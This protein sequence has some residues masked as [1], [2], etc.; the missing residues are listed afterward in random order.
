MPVTNNTV[1][2]AIKSQS[3]Y[4]TPSLQ[5]L[6]HLLW[7]RRGASGHVDQVWPRIYLGDKWTAK[8]KRSLQSLKITHILNAAD[9]KYNVCTGA[10][11]YSDMNIL[12]HGVEAFDTTAFDI[13][14][15]FYSAAKFIR[16]ALDTPGDGK[17]L[18]HCAM[19]L[20]RSAT[21][22]LAFLM[23]YENKTLVDAVKAVSEHRNIS[24]NMGFLGQLRELDMRLND[25]RKLRRDC[26]V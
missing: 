7:T 25:E 15:F 26:N 3:E 2:S 14:P 19:G 1:S 12:Y 21:L 24:P 13:S 8:D 18:V 22:V 5:D 10:R 16:K 4:I 9:G 11:Y 17:V 23:I 20:S 6:Q